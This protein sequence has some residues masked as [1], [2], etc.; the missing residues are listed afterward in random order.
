MAAT[1]P[2]P[3]PEPQPATEPR[4]LME[5]L[6]GSERNPRRISPTRMEALKKALREFGDLGGICL[7]I[8]TRH[9]VGGHQRV[10]AFN[11]DRSAKVVI[12]QRLEEPDRTGTVAFG[13]IETNGTRYGYREV[14]WDA[15]REQAANLAANQHSG[16]WDT[17]MLGDILKGMDEETQRLA[18][19]EQDDLKSLGLLE[20]P[21]TGKDADPMA[22][23]AAELNKKWQ[24]KPGD[25][26]K[27]G[28]HRLLC[29]DSTKSPDVKRLMAG[30][31]AQMLFCDPPY[32][33]TYDGGDKYAKIANDEKTH[34]DLLNFLTAAFGAAA[35]HLLDDASG[36]VWHASATAS[37]FRAALLRA[38]LVEKQQIIWVKPS[39]TMGRDDYQW[40]HEP[41]L[42]CHKQGHQP[43]W[44]GD[45]KQTSVWNVATKS[46]KIHQ[47]IV[48]NGLFL[49]SGD[50]SIQIL[51]KAPK[52]R[53]DR[54]IRLEDGDTL[55]LATVDFR[56][57]VW[58]VRRDSTGMHPTE[59]PPALAMI[60]IA[61]S[62][63]PD[64][65]V[66]DNFGGSGTT[67]VACQRTGRRCMSLEFSENYCAVQ[68]ERM[69]TAFSITGTRI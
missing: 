66:L 53:K 48:G 47:A 35:P 31:K 68:L 64:D 7:N 62:T 37:D 51:H 13:H 23:K 19:F 54:N 18:G 15:A 4:S 57:T 34:N 56:S 33:I 2:K 28:D 11:A 29:G 10:T 49:S 16:E 24:C 12:T 1:K 14:S 60:A 65:V 30:M 45:R 63:Q 55:Q 32:G 25:L 44:H 50:D 59:K 52:E 69:E 42:Y 38:G 67:M 9:L 61:N 40:S 46:G 3:T 22:N 17:D 41:A 21:D 36:Y 58:H 39:L 26:W 5:Q 20:K 8:Q 27:I 43:K 6:P